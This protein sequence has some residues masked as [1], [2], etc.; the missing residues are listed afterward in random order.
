LA[1]REDGFSPNPEPRAF[2]VRLVLSLALLCAIGWAVLRGLGLSAGQS[3][4]WSA[5]AFA[6]GLGLVAL[7]Q[8]ARA[9]R[10]PASEVGAWLAGFML[11]G[12]TLVIARMTAWH[13]AFPFLLPALLWL[14]LAAVLHLRRGRG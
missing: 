11:L 13:V 12:A 9:R 14:G 7:A 6:G 2:L 3:G 4:L 5:A 1:Q 10:W 8:V